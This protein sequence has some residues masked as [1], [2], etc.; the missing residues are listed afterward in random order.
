MYLAG[1]GVEKSVQ[2]A[3]QYFTKAADLGSAD[4][5]FHLGMLQVRANGLRG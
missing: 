3:Q 4:A 1:A 2:K 5:H